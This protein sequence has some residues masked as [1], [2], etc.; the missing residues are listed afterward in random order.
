MRFLRFL[1]N[2][3]GDV[4]VFAP[5]IHVFLLRH[6][7]VRVGSIIVLVYLDF[8]L[9]PDDVPESKHEITLVPL[10]LEIVHH[11]RGRI[12]LKEVYHLDVEFFSYILIRRADN[13]FVWLIIAEEF[14][15][16]I[17]I[18]LEITEADDFSEA[19]FLVED[20]VGTAECL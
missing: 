5:E 19:F 14:D 20:A 12:F 8:Y 18:A 3:N 17:H 10:A 1:N 11:I 15:G 2:A 16:S 6:D 4:E 13:I 9:A 7:E